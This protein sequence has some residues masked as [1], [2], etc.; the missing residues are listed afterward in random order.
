[1]S[2][3]KHYDKV[4]IF[5]LFEHHLTQSSIHQAQMLFTQQARPV[6]EVSVYYRV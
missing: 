4:N 1:M 3:V 5:H 6:R 2:V